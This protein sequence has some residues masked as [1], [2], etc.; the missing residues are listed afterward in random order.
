[1]LGTCLRNTVRKGV[2]ASNPVERAD[3]PRVERAEVGK[4]LSRD[5]LAALVKGFT[6][7]PLHSIVAVAVG[8][9]ARR[10]EV[11]GLR[12]SDFDA[13]AK[14]LRFARTVEE[15]KAHGRRTKS[16]KTK[17][18]TRTVAVD[19]GLVAMLR[20]EYETHQRLMTGIPDGATAD[21]SLVRLPEGALIFPAPAVPFDCAKLRDAHAVTRTFQRQARKLGFAGLRF[22]DPRHSHGSLLLAAHLSIPVVAARLGHSPDVLLRTYAHVIKDMDERETTA[23]VLG[24]LSV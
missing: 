19:D 5:Q 15:T 11:L 10:N 7:H 6:G 21:L 12:W 4:A 23:A 14:T 22:H 16:P 18:G 1:M 9:G 24:A 17:Q 8:T 20:A 13:S 3:A 2:I